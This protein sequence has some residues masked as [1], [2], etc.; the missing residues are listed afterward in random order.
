[1]AYPQGAWSETA[2]ISIT[3]YGAAGG[4]DK[5]YAALTETI[6]IDLGDKDIEQMTGLLGGKMVKKVPM[7]VTTITF[8][9]YPL[10]MDATGSTGVSQMFYGETTWDITEPLAATVTIQRDLFRVVILWTDSTW[11]TQTGTS[12][13]ATSSN[14]YRMAFAHCYMTSCKPSFTDGVLKLTFVFK[15][16]AFNKNG[17]GLIHEDSGDAT[18]IPALVSYGSVNYPPDGSTAYTW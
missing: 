9:G 10:D 18:A 12:A 17:V 14:A 1:M 3:R 16:V 2:F 13:T 8:E 7:D 6:D 5:S 11:T 15:C 4:T